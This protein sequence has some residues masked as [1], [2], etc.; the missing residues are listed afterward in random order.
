MVRKWKGKVKYLKNRK[1]KGK[2]RERKWL[3]F[4]FGLPICVGVFVDYL[5]VNFIKNLKIYLSGVKLRDKVVPMRDKWGK[6]KS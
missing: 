6:V 5:P 2:K 3:G 4:E 1:E